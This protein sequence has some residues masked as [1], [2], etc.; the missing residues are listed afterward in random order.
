[1]RGGG[2][3]ADSRQHRCGSPPQPFH[4][5]ERQPPVLSLSRR[6]TLTALIPP[7]IHAL[8]H[9]SFIHSI[10]FHS[11]GMRPHTAP[12]LHT[13]HSFTH[14][15]IHFIHSDTVTFGAGHNAIWG[16]TQC[17]LGPDIVPF[18]AG[19]IAIWGPQVKACL[20][21]NSLIHGPQFKAQL[22]F[23]TLFCTC[24]CL[25]WHT[26]SLTAPPIHSPTHSLI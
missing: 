10:H 21:P 1:M 25:H 16:R 3:P 12:I 5:S 6:H 11:C 14:L 18:G 24:T 17:H 22:I 7:L 15:P 20:N 19:H 8:I 23:N 9:H 26:H 2:I 4:P 13:S